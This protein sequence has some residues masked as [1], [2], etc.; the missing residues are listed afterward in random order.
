MTGTVYAG[1]SPSPYHQGLCV[2]DCGVPFQSEEPFKVSSGNIARNGTGL[3]LAHMLMFACV[4]RVPTSFDAEPRTEPTSLVLSGADTMF[5]SII[6]ILFRNSFPTPCF[7]N[8]RQP[9]LQCGNHLSL[10]LQLQHNQSGIIYS[11]V[12]IGILYNKILKSNFF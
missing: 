2:L 4:Q 8:L 7:L 10:P 3:Y 11:F 9:F 12:S 6:P 1:W 5:P